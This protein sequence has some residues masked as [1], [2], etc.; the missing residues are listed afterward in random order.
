MSQD[1]RNVIVRM[2]DK[3]LVLPRPI[4]RLGLRLIGSMP[5]VTVRCG[6]VPW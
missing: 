1:G 2:D 4:V 5:A 3:R 6:H